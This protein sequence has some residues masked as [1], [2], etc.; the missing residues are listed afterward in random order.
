MIIY[1]ESL[2]A[3]IIIFIFYIFKNFFW[4]L[5]LERKK[6]QEE[7]LQTPRLSWTLIPLVTMRESTREAEPVFGFSSMIT[8]CFNYSS[9]TT[10]ADWTPTTAI[11]L[12]LA[13]RLTNVVRCFWLHVT[14][15]AFC[16]GLVTEL[17]I[18]HQTI[19]SLA[20]FRQQPPSSSLMNARRD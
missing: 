19:R 15:H 4:Y 11:T 13:A 12:S 17:L 18:I 9:V 5:I 7:E 16:V 20:T 6:K 2:G 3:F 8:A 1:H 14:S 10:L